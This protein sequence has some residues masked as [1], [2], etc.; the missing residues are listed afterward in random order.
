[1]EYSGKHPFFDTARIRTYP[2][3]M[4]A[5]KVALAD[6]VFAADAAETAFDGDPAVR[7]SVESIVTEIL[8]CRRKGAP[9]IL[10]TGAHLVKNGLGPL[11]VDLVD[12]GMFSLI[13]GNAATAIHD[14]ELAMI[15]QTS[16]SVPNALARGEFGMASEFGCFN[17][18]L[19]L[20]NRER[21]GLGESLGRMIC[22]PDFRDEALALIGYTGPPP[23]F[24]NPEV[25]LLVACHR[26]GIP[27]TVHAGIGTDV[28]DQHSSFDGEAKG[29]CSGRDFLIFTG[30]VAGFTDGGVVLNIGSAVQGPEVL[31]KA[32]SMAANTGAA[33][34]GLVTADFDIRPYRPGDMTDESAAGY[35]ARDQK[36]VVTR[37]PDAFGGRGVYVQ[38]NQKET[39]PLLYKCLV[40]MPGGK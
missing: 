33:P 31:L 23:R 2:L 21:L 9:V 39:V 3:D 10:F 24:S 36:S 40:G 18:A 14:F 13:A 16:E 30:H 38:G 27:M 7:E 32:V 37:I 19:A 1:M 35:Y 25:S 26:K 29:G 5:N 12:R 6:L 22:E 17:A 34:R 28:I 11:I 15:G 4:R 8:T 20:G